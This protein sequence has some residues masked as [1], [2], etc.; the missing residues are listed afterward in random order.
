MD[1]FVNTDGVADKCATGVSGYRARG[2]CVIVIV[3]GFAQTEGVYHAKGQNIV[4][5][6]WTENVWGHRRILYKHNTLKMYINA[7]W[8]C[9]GIY[10]QKVLLNA[11]G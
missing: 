3:T 7:E 2:V 8:Q 4:V 5:H 10:S 11:G 6:R 1:M 9:L